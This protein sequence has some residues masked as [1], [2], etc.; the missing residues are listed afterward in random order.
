MKIRSKLPVGVQL[1][2]LGI[3][4]G[5]LI[6]LS[7]C[8][9][10]KPAG[11]TDTSSPPQAGASFITPGSLGRFVLP[12]IPLIGAGLGTISFLYLLLIRHQLIDQSRRLKGIR[13]QL[14]DLKETSA[15]L[16]R[17]TRDL[18]RSLVT[19]EPDA[20]ISVAQ[21]NDL[22][23]RHQDYATTVRQL[24]YRVIT[25]ENELRSLTSSLRG[26]RGPS[27]LSSPQTEAEAVGN[28]PI[29]KSVHSTNEHGPAS[30][31][32][33]SEEKEHQRF[34]EE[35]VD[36]F[37]DALSRNDRSLIRAATDAEL[38]ITTESEEALVRGT[39]IGTT[40]L[41][42]VAGGGS[43][44]L[45]RHRGRA[46]LVPTF[47][48]FSAFTSLRPAKGIFEY[49]ERPVSIATLIKPAELEQ[50]GEN[51]EVVNMG[52]VAVPL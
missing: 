34:I 46:W 2:L 51:W 17:K 3:V 41:N 45:V 25:I 47:Q 13:E 12:L 36:K 27:P 28:T 43:Y 8:T 9:A 7:S 52:L 38:N 20:K 29:N 30:E 4:S 21:F 14:K 39:A 31:E 33:E 19:T 48:T 10:N 5:L 1:L 11:G 49:S 23:R 6:S 44:L 15:Q 22:T 40:Q 18:E 32:T 24:D 26:N 16:Q 42:E 35:L 37:N 50:T